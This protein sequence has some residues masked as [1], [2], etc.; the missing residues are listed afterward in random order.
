MNRL[1]T[2]ILTHPYKKGQRILVTSDI[3]GHPDH[4]RGVLDAAGFCTDDLLVI[5]GDVVE[6]GPDSLGALRLVMELASRGNALVLLGNVDAWRVQMTEGVS[7]DNAADFWDYLC[8]LHNWCGS[9]FYAEMAQE[10]GHTLTSAEDVLQAKEA[11]LAQ[12]REELD[13]LA[14]RP[15]VVQIGDFVFVH[16]GLRHQTLSDNADCD[17][18]ALTK[19]DRFADAAPFSFP[20]R[21]VCGHWPTALYNDCIQQ[22]NPVFRRDKN[23]ISID[24]GCGIKPEGQLNLL[25]IP[26]AHCSDDEIH[27]MYYDTLPKIRALEEQK[28][29]TDSVHINWLHSE[30]TVLA[31]G[32]EFSEVEHLHSGR[33]LSVPTRYLYKGNRCRD[34]TDRQLGVKAGDIL[35]LYKTTSRGCIVK[36]DGV[37]GWYCGNYETV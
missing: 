36:K 2:E 32:E 22:F 35:S 8:G 23:I 13:F 25:I 10:C 6:K 5:V 30:I 15:T 20:F 34:Y 1:N 4:L 14:S 33:K 11:I 17:V 21:V 37:M 9:S 3:H 7:E 26:D 16:G 12:F 28:E 31:H 18:Y 29:S 27:H 24:G 19:Y